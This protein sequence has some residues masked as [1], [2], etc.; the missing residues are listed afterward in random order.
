[1]PWLL[2]FLLVAPTL[3]CWWAQR[4]YQRIAWRHMTAAGAAA[5]RDPFWRGLLGRYRPEHFD[6][7]GWQAHRLA[8]LCFWAAPLWWL[9]LGLVIAPALGLF[10]PRPR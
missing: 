10:G 9:V 4:Y 3:V 7:I 8:Q 2:L 6:L 1:M 5:E